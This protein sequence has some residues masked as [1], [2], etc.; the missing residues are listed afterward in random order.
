MLSRAQN[1]L[2]DIIHSRLDFDRFF[3]LLC[4]LLVLR[5]AETGVHRH[6]AH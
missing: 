3:C 6:S 1:H 2:H 5:F 4:I